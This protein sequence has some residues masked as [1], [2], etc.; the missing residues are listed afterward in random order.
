MRDLSPVAEA[1]A[2]IPIALRADAK[3][4]APQRPLVFVC[5]SLSGL[6]VYVPS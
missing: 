6:V 5:H 3:Q 4:A 2:A 1:L